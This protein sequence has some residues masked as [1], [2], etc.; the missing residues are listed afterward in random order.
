MSA[1][2]GTAENQA[3]IQAPARTCT[4]SRC[5]TAS[6]QTSP[7][8]TLRPCAA[9]KSSGIFW[10]GQGR[11]RS[12]PATCRCFATTN[13]PE[14]DRLGVGSGVRVGGAP[15]HL[16]VDALARSGVGYHDRFLLHA[17][18]VALAQPLPNQM[19]HLPPEPRYLPPVG[20]VDIPT[21]GYLPGVPP[22]VQQPADVRDVVFAPGLLLDQVEEVLCR[23]ARGFVDLLPYRVHCL[24]G[25]ARR[26]SGLGPH[27]Q[28][29]LP[30]VKIAAAPLYAS[31]GSALHVDRGPCRAHAVPFD[32]NVEPHLLSHL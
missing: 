21:N 17:H 11:A 30:V 13:H 14:G 20:P 32:Q 26:P 31:R 10:N 29:S 25:N 16:G 6:Y 5:L 27:S 12:P 19:A 7:A 8:C 18:H 22:A 4:G 23:P 28:P 2:C 24:P 15:V 1:S 3:G 9:G